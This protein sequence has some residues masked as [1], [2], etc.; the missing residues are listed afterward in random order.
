M[1]NI[2]TCGLAGAGNQH[3]HVYTVNTGSCATLDLNQVAYT[4]DRGC[5]NDPADGVRLENVPVTMG[6]PIYIE[7][8][9]ALSNTPFTW[10][11]EYQGGGGGGCM[12]YA[13]NDVPINIPDNTPAGIN[14]VINVT[15]GGVVSDINIKN[16][17]GNHT[18]IGA[19]VFKLQ[20]PQGTMVTLI[21][22]A[23][24]TNG[25]TD[26]NISLDDQ[27][28]NALSCPYNTGNT[29][30]PENAL[31]IFN[32]QNPMGNWTLTV[33]DNDEFGDVGALNGW[34]LEVCTQGGGNCPPTLAVNNSP[35]A[36]GTFQAGTQLTSSGSVGAGNTVIFRAGNNVQLLP[37]FTVPLTSIFEARI[38]G[39][40]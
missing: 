30:Q 21:N 5:T 2:F 28:T 33:A 40:P 25:G 18:Y 32:G 9:D 8:D 17:N 15:T 34:T 24:N 3:N 12:D 1:I 16:L 20:S 7:W 38:A 39:C 29:E 19:L 31:A 13:A 36:G 10:T 27:A 35:I 22:N 23:C 26:F 6:V 37:N 14:S 4:E 11:L